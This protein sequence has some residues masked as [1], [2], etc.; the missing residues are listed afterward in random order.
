MLRLIRSLDTQKAHG[1]DDISIAMIKICD[2]S[3]LDPL[4][5]IFEKSLET[6][7]YPRAWKKANV[8]PIHKKESKQSLPVFGKLFEK[9]I[10]D[11]IYFHLCENGLLTPNQSGFRPEDSTINQLLCITHKIYSASEDTP[12]KET[13]AVFLDLSKAFER[14]WHKGLL[15]KLEHNGISGDLLNLNRTF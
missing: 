2:A 7:I 14:V 1:C 3:I 5:Y 15:Y 4:G 8:I 11:D 9:I 10:F 13:R 6:R 12:S